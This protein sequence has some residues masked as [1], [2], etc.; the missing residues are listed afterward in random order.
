MHDDSL[1]ISGKQPLTLEQAI[2][3]LCEHQKHVR[4]DIKKEALSQQVTIAPVNDRIKYLAYCISLLD[5]VDEDLLRLM[6]VNIRTMYSRRELAEFFKWFLG[7]KVYF[8]TDEQLAHETGV[9]LN[10][11]KDIDLYAQEAVFRAIKHKRQV[12][13]PLVGAS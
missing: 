13:V 2:N 1:I 11:I 9:P 3:Y 4:E 6:P 10:L 8:A 5:E 7:Q 12:G